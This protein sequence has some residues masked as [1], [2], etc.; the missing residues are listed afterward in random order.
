MRNRISGALAVLLLISVIDWQTANLEA[1][2]G[3]FDLATAIVQ[4]QQPA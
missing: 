1:L 4:S 3:A 2:R